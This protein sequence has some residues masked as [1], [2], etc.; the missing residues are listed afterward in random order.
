MRN[1]CGYV[2]LSGKSFEERQC[3]HDELKNKSDMHRLDDF[4]CALVAI[5]S[6]HIDIVDGTHGGY[7]ADQRKSKG[8]M[9]QEFCLENQLCVSNTWLKR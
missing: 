4:L 2:L 9:T 5:M 8:R 3:Y 1:I 7:D 6:R